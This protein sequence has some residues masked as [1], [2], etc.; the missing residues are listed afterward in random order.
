MSFSPPFPPPPDLR[1]LRQ[2]L[3]A[4][5]Q[6]ETLVDEDSFDEDDDYEILRALGDSVANASLL[7]RSTMNNVSGLHEKSRGVA[8]N[9][10]GLEGATDPER[11]RADRKVA[12]HK[13]T[14]SNW[15]ITL[16]DLV[17][18]ASDALQG[19]I[20][21]D[22]RLRQL[23]AQLEQAHKWANPKIHLQMCNIMCE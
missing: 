10:I 5:E 8:D 12:A 18:Q 16:Q 4:E 9:G 19:T 1:Q 3:S 22:K 11:E 7:N 6:D 17:T 13:N 2:A 15:L 20:V 14:F 23:N 21:S